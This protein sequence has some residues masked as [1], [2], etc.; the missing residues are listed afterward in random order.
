MNVRSTKLFLHIS[1]AVIAIL[2]AAAILGYFIL[3]LWQIEFSFTVTP[4]L[5]DEIAK[6]YDPAPSESPQNTAYAYIGAGNNVFFDETT[7]STY[8]SEKDIVLAV[9]QAMADSDLTFSMSGNLDTSTFVGAIFDRST[10]K[11]EK[12]IEKAVDKFASDA[13]VIISDVVDAVIGTVAKEV[14]KY[15]VKEIIKE[16]IDV[17][18]ADDF[19]NEIGIDEARVD[20]MIDTAITAV[21]AEDATVTSITDTIMSMSDEVIGLLAESEKYAEDAAKI[22]DEDKEAIRDTIIETISPYAD[23]NGRINLKEALVTQVLRLASD[24]LPDASSSSQAFNAK[25]GAPKATYAVVLTNK[26]SEKQAYA[27]TT[28]GSTSLSYNDTV[29]KLK[30]QLK[31]MLIENIDPSVLNAVMTVMPVIGIVVLVFLIMLAYP[32]I[33][34]LTKIGSKNPGFHLALPIIAGIIP[35]IL[36]VAIPGAFMRAAKSGTLLSSLNIPEE[37]AAVLDAI[38]VTFSSC[39]LIAFIVALVLFVYSFVYGHFRRKLAK[40][41]K[42]APAAEAPVEPAAEFSAVQSAPAES[43]TADSTDTGEN[44]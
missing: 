4:E 3:P 11:L 35:F 41:L 10:G 22:T 31:T 19:L 33:R 32:I 26:G 30:N 8:I 2:C 15:Q 21:T 28:L 34:A 9:A 43:E 1:N 13:E 12:E 42:T 38:T 37:T 5:V 17:E 16:N 24:A 20:R 27:E 25:N 18:I 23:E 7:E 40:A 6:S 39:T 14:V 44:N 36:M 29:A